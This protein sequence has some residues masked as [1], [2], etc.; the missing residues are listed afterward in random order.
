MNY[1][2]SQITMRRVNKFRYNGYLAHKTVEKM[3][4]EKAGISVPYTFCVGVPSGSSTLPVLIRTPIKSGIAGEVAKSVEFENGQIVRFVTRFLPY[5]K[6]G[7]GAH[8][9]KRKFINDSVDRELK[10]LRAA[11]G[12]G[13][14][15]DLINE[16]TIN[17]T[18][19]IKNNNNRF[20]LSD[21]TLLV[22]ATIT[23]P[24]K[25]E[26]AY[27]NGIGAKSNFGYGMILMEGGL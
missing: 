23:D 22:E 16:V 1:F 4:F 27:M 9:D 8:K 19:F 5:M 25:F 18:N 11:E 7:S 17:T 20:T 2:E 14:D 10:F 24:A 26:M 3:V 15:V 13:L 6:V 21:V 12:A